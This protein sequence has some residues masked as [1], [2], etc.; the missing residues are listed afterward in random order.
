M[1]DSAVAKVLHD[2]TAVAE[3][4]HHVANVDLANLRNKRNCE[5]K[6][7]L[8]DVKPPAS[9]V[10]LHQYWHPHLFDRQTDCCCSQL[11][12]RCHRRGSLGMYIIKLNPVSY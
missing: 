11:P 9:A 7:S 8:R 5:Y 1:R 3:H 10:S 2:Q 12:R 6:L 4:V